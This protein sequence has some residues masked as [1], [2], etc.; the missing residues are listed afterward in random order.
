MRILLALL[1]PLALSGCGL[2]IKPDNPD[3]I[4]GPRQTFEDHERRSGGA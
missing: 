1:A 2:L 4:Y 3:L